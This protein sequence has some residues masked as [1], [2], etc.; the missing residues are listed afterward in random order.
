MI[1]KSL[2]TVSPPLTTRQPSTT[3]AAAK[4]RPSS[5]SCRYNQASSSALYSLHSHFYKILFGTGLD[6]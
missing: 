2:H 3:S 4:L 6:L 5:R 1:L